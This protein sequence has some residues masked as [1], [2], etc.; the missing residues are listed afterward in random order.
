MTISNCYCK[1]KEFHNH[2]VQLPKITISLVEKYRF[3]LQQ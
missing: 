1:Q 3:R 2:D